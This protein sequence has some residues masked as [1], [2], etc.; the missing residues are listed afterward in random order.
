MFVAGLQA[1]AVQEPV[2]LGTADSF[3][4]L[5]GSAITDTGPTTISGDIGTFPTRGPIWS[6]AGPASLTGTREVAPRPR[7]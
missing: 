4:V 3:A 6:G 5:A 1:S 7:H 2:G